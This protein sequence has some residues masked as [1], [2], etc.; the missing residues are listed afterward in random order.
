MHRQ[1]EE[2]A[3][4]IIS[5]ENVEP[6]LGTEAAR[7]RHRLRLPVHALD[8][9]LRIHG[10]ADERAL[11]IRR[12]LEGTSRSN[13]FLSGSGQRQKLAKATYPATRPRRAVSFRSRTPANPLSAPTGVL[14]QLMNHQHK[15]D[16]QPPRFVPFDDAG[17]PI[18]SLPTARIAGSASLRGRPP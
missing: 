15:C 7:H 14:F 12:V 17:R 4:V 13:V 2:P 9:A 5:A 1:S 16:L 6:L 8:N 10:E 18:S 3:L 11:R